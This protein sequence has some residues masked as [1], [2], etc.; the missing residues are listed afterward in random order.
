MKWTEMKIASVMVEDLSLI[1]M[2]EWWK[3]YRVYP[4]TALQ[5]MQETQACQFIHY[6]LA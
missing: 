1:W 2:T 4:E 5:A 3:V 6:L